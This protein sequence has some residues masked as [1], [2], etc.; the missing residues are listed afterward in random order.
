MNLLRRE[1]APISEAG[2]AEIDDQAKRFFRP[3]LTARKYMDVSGPFGLDYAAVTRGRLTVPPGQAT[4]EVA[5][6]VHQVQ[7][8]VEVRAPFTLDV[9]EL[10]NIERGAKDVDFAPMEEAA[11]KL[12][13]FEEDAI[14]RGF[15][16]SSIQGLEETQERDTIPF[17]GEITTFMA[18][19]TEGITRLRDAMVEGPYSL[20]VTPKVWSELSS[21]VDG[22]PLKHHLEYLIEGP[23]VTGPYVEKSFLVSTRGGDLEIT[24]GQDISIGY[25]T[26]DPETVQL[27]FTESLTFSIHDPGVV[28]FFG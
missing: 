9:W 28:V 13:K 25:H 2:W 16:H 5:Y 22:R 1:L 24:L 7:P 8:L 10:D 18:S 17:G 6:G 27:Y 3:I 23:I 19:V 15:K 4:D 20:V 21:C 12:A 11:H 26:H 14:Y